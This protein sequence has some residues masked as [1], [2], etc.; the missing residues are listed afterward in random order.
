MVP[1]E[2]AQFAN[3]ATMIEVT[4]GDAMRQRKAEDTLSHLQTHIGGAPFALFLV[5]DGH[6]GAA[7][8]HHLRGHLLERI[9]AKASS[10]CSSFVDPSC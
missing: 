2:R 3:P 1:T 7:T 6:G 4:F 9:A 8:A 5:A 10:I